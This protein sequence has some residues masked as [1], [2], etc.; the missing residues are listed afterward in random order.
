MSFPKDHWQTWPSED[1][2]TMLCE[3]WLPVMAS[4]Y[5]GWLCPPP[6]YRQDLAMG[7]DLARMSHWR[8]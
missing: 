7:K 2:L 5:T 6:F 4:E 1:T 3:F 8:M